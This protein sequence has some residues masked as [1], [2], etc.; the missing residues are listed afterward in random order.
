MASCWQKLDQSHI[1]LFSLAS[2]IYQ[3]RNKIVEK[4]IEMMKRGRIIAKQIVSKAYVL[5][6]VQFDLFFR[7]FTLNCIEIWFSTMEQGPNWLF[8]VLLLCS[9]I[10]SLNTIKIKL[11]K[12]FKPYHPNKKKTHRQ[13]V[14]FNPSTKHSLNNFC[15]SSI[16]LATKF[17]RSW[18]HS[19]E[20]AFVINQSNLHRT[21]HISHSHI[22]I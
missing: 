19:H 8:S 22:R 12:S 15:V 20:S 7:F 17:D 16:L 18:L 10:H 13:F 11:G 4:S 9:F 6:K 14:Q 3:I 5:R 2:N 21:F 1:I